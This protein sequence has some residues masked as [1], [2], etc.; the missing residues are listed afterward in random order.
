MISQS[1]VMF[2]HMATSVLRWNSAVFEIAFMLMRL[3]HVNSFIENV[4]HSVLHSLL[5]FMSKQKKALRQCM[6]E[7]TIAFI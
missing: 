6:D 2:H 4:N 7:Y 5:A 3:D 1:A